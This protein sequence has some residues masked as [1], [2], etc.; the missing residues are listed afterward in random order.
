MATRGL[1]IKLDISEC[2]AAMREIF[3]LFGDGAG[4]PNHI[5]S[6]ISRLKSGGDALVD[7]CYAERAVYPGHELLCILAELRA[8]RG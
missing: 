1:V 4:V 5:V 2:R 7:A 3:E 6:R 8:L